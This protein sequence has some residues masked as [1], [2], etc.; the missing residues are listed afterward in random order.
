[1]L[2][3]IYL[4]G[5]TGSPLRHMGSSIFVVAHRLFHLRHA[6]SRSLTK[7]RTLAP[8]IGSSELVTGPLG[9]PKI[10]HFLSTSKV[11]SFSFLSLN[12]WGHPSLWLLSYKSRSDTREAQG[13]ISWPHKQPTLSSPHRHHF[14]CV[15][16]RFLLVSFLR[17][18]F[19]RDD[20]KISAIF[21]VL[22]GSWERIFSHYFHNQPPS[23]KWSQPKSCSTAG[24]QA[25]VMGSLAPPY[26]PP[27][28]PPGDA[29]RWLAG[30]QL[31]CGLTQLF[32]A[33]VRA[34]S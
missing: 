21:F 28:P 17:A 11:K 3:F 14:F 29:R 10:S 22:L 6:R 23:H 20:S 7:D 1:M 31:Y 2:I 4:F 5:C 32:P 25:G 12:H 33:K 34:S 18:D 19:A 9:K 24:R 15:D 30:C 16:L 13:L 27:L 26:I 8:C